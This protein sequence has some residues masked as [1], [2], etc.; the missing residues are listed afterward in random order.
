MRDIF[1][2]EIRDAQPVD[3]VSLIEELQIFVSNTYEN[4]SFY[5]ANS[6]LHCPLTH[7]ETAPYKPPHTNTPPPRSPPHTTAQE[8]ESTAPS[9]T[10]TSSP[11]PYICPAAESPASPA[12]R[13]SSCQTSDGDTATP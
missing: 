5:I 8:T 11:K 12:N 7:Q 10:A 2:N 3:Y 13:A 1:F 4:E 6:A 9:K